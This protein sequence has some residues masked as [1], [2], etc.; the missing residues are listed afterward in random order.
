VEHLTVLGRGWALLVLLAFPFAISAMRRGGRA[1]RRRVLLVGLLL[2]Y[3]A[4]VVAVTIFPIYVVPAGWR[5]DD[6][7]YSVVRLIPFVVPPVGFV[8]NIVMFMPFGILLP[9]LWPS[10]GTWRRMAAWG[11]AAS[12]TIEFT[13]LGMWIAIGNRRMFDVNDLM[14][15]TAGAVLG[16]MLLRAFVPERAEQRAEVTAGRR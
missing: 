9:L 3:A 14:S 16:L 2:L 4:G 6:H 5:W 13:Q 15:N 11:L 8:L 7:W 12:A 1:S 10:T